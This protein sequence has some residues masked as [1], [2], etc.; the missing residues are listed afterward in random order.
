MPDNPTTNQPDS[1]E[2][3]EFT[4][5]WN[6]VR[7]AIVCRRCIEPKEAECHQSKHDPNCDCG[8]C[9]YCNG[10]EDVWGN[11]TRTLAELRRDFGQPEQP[12]AQTAQES[13][14]IT[15]GGE[16]L[17]IFDIMQRFRTDGSCEHVIKQA[18]EK[19]A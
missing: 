18:L 1:R 10:Q 13:P 2:R 3:H 14:W 15:S 7:D 17:S 6:G 5:I 4:A 9:A 16:R 19:L 11:R 12:P 8:I